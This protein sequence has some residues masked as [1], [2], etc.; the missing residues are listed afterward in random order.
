[1]INFRLVKQKALQISWKGFSGFFWVENIV[2]KTFGRTDD[3]YHAMSSVLQNCGTSCANSPLWIQAIRYT[4]CF[5]F[6]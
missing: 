5:S 6:F 4:F 3:L 2:P 1:M